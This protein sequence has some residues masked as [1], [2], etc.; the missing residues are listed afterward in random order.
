MIVTALPIP[1]MF[2]SSVGFLGTADRMV[3][4]FDGSNPRWR[5]AAI[6]ENFKWPNVLNALSDSLYVCTQT[7]LCPGTLSITT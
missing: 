1:F 6:L 3:P 4:F 2:G 5:P 7:L